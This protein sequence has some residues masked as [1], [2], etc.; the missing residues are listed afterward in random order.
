MSII[1]DASIF[2]SGLTA[3]KRKRIETE[4]ANVLLTLSKNFD[5]IIGSRDRGNQLSRIT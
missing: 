1:I 5:F 3:K 2:I 4:K